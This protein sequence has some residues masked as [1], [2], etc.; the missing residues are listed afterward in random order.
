[1]PGYVVQTGLGENLRRYCI[2]AP[3][4]VSAVQS[5]A[6]LLGTPTQ[7]DPYWVAL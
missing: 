1:M 5:A 6:R 7:G 2:E 3:D 4:E